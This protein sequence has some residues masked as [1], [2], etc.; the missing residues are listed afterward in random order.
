MSCFFSNLRVHARHCPAA[1]LRAAIANRFGRETRV[2]DLVPV[3]SPDM[4]THAVAVEIAVGW[5]RVSAANVGS[6]VRLSCRDQQARAARESALA[7]MLDH[8]AEWVSAMTGRQELI[9]PGTVAG[10][11]DGLPE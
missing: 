9:D 8:T 5:P 11:A 7:P 2:S 10:L 4:A 3:A 6:T 1:D